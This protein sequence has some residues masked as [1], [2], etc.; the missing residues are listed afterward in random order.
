MKLRYQ[1]PAAPPS[2]A[3]IAPFLQYLQQQQQIFLKYGITGSTYQKIL[4]HCPN[5]R[6]RQSHAFSSQMPRTKMQP[7]VAIREIVAH[8]LSSPNISLIYFLN[9]TMKKVPPKA[10]TKPI[11]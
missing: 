2:A 8:R 7:R 9:P 4:P 3:F 6:N 5:I 11:K 10:I 1:S